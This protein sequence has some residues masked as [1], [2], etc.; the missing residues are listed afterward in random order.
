MRVV[1]GVVLR[2]LMCGRLEEFLFLATRCSRTCRQAMP[3][4]PLGQQ[5]S[6]DN[7]RVPSPPPPSPWHSRLSRWAPPVDAFRALSFSRGCSAD[8]LGAVLGTGQLGSGHLGHVLPLILGRP[9]IAS[10]KRT[11]SGRS[12]FC[13]AGA[14][15]LPQFRC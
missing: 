5:K 12:C 6:E 9:S 4:H 2:I 10:P 1:S 3:S 14:R 15:H 7:D 11:A 8:I 13:P